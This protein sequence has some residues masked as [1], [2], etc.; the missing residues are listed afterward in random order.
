MFSERSPS[1]AHTDRTEELTQAAFAVLDDMP[2]IAKQADIEKIRSDIAFAEGARLTDP[3]TW[4]RRL[5][6]SYR[7]YGDAGYLRRMQ[8]LGERITGQRLAAHAKHIFKSENAAVAGQAAAWH[9]RQS[10]NAASN[11]PAAA[12]TTPRL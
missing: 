4:L 10:R 5:A 7:R 1:T 8:G 2:E 12:A 11:D 9:E 3:N 6:L